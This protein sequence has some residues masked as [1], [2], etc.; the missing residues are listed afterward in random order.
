VGVREKNLKLIQWTSAIAVL[1]IVINRLNIS[2]I[3]FNYHLP[4]EDR[5]FPHWMEFAISI[6]IVTI[7]VLVFRFIVTRMPVLYEH[8]D[9]EPH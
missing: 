6:F 8:P 5:Y 2:L 4:A 9:Y 3:A 7:G 1:G